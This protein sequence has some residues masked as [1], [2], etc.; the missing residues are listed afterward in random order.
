MK[1]IVFTLFLLA[2]SVLSIQAQNDTDAGIML[3]NE[4]SGTSLSESQLRKCESLMKDAQWYI[5]RKEFGRAKSKLIELLTINPND[6]QAKVLLKQCK[7]YTSTYG[8][9]AEQK[10]T[11]F[12]L[13]AV[14]G[15]DLFEKN[16]GI[17]LGVT[18]KY[19]SFKDLMNITGGLL[20]AI[21]QSYHGRADVLENYTRAVTLGGQIIIPVTFQ[22]NLIEVTKDMR[23]YAGPGA[24]FGLKLYAKNIKNQGWTGTRKYQLMNNSTISGLLKVGIAGRHF[25]AGIYYKHY[26]TDFVNDNFPSYQE[27]SRIGL[28]A[29]Y[30]F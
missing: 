30:Y 13:G 12:T 14:L 9:S 1:K 25:D 19:G 24:E 16:Y 17:Y 27:N 22:F 7:D 18:A 26:I 20:F 2:G 3:I 29:A 28:S 11:K 10:P 23:F 8:E 5:K 6:N 21:Q 15:T 4:D